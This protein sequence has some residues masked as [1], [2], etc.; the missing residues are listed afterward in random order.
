MYLARK[1]AMP[2][3]CSP[4]KREASACPCKGFEFPKLRTTKNTQITDQ[5]HI[6]LVKEALL[7][8]VLSKGC[9]SSIQNQ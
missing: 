5:I 9:I 1:L 8:N 7:Q 3:Y 2:Y 4:S 6:G